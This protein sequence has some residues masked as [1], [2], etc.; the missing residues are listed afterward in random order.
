MQLVVF[1]DEHVNRLF[2]ITIGRPAYAIN[3]GS[4]RLI[5]WL[6]RLSHETGVVL[7]GVVRPHL[8]TIQKLD[9]PQI[10]STPPTLDTPLLVI[11]ARLVPSVASYH[12]LRA[13]IDGL[14]TVAVGESHS[15]AAAMIGPGGPAP[16]PDDVAEHWFKYS[17]NS[18]IDKLPPAATKLSLFHYPHDVVRHNLHII[19]PNLNHRLESGHY[20]EVAAGV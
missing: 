9:F 7:R 16:P 20:Q 8:R 17:H 3:C 15:L 6:E 11:N 13:L 12:A 19:E 1:E 18:L 4:Y 10:R 5:D 2:P 14:E